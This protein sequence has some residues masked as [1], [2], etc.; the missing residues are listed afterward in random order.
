[1]TVLIDHLDVLDLVTG[2]FFFCCPAWKLTQKMA[3]GLPLIT[4]FCLYISLPLV[5]K[6]PA[7]I[8]ILWCVLMWYFVCWK[9]AVCWEFALQAITSV[10]HF[11]LLRFGDFMRVLILN[12]RGGNKVEFE[13]D[14]VSANLVFSFLFCLLRGSIFTKTVWYLLLP[15]AFSNPILIGTDPFETGPGILVAHLC[16]MCNCSHDSVLCCCFRRYHSLSSMGNPAVTRQAS[17][18]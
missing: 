5:R 3:N 8:Y 16:I 18:S 14:G 10:K 12:Q 9:F 17:C 7:Y 1:M 2:L 4:A 11:L 15:L 13:Y 6:P